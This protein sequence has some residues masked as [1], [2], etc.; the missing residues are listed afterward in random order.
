MNQTVQAKTFSIAELSQEFGVST[1]TLR[2][3]E[4]KH[5]LHPTRS[6]KNRLY[7]LA[8]YTRLRLILRGKRLGF[9]LQEIREII[10]LYQPKNN[11]EQLHFLLEKID[12]R[13]AVLKQQQQDIDALMSDLSLIEQQCIDSLHIHRTDKKTRL[14]MSPIWGQEGRPL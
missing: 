9:S 11:T 3:Y 13:K 7:H 6:G 4:G 12:H 2:F 10:E 14:A 8:D 1:R 5:L